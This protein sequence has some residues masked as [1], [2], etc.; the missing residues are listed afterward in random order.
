MD[1]WRK[2]ALFPY[3]LMPAAPDTC[4]DKSATPGS[5]PSYQWYTKIEVARQNCR[6]AP[7]TWQKCDEKFDW[8]FRNNLFEQNLSSQIARLNPMHREICGIDDL[9]HVANRVDLFFENRRFWTV[10]KMPGPAPSAFSILGLIQDHR[11]VCQTDDGL[12]KN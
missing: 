12:F 10:A 9:I 3:E 2:A 4:F 11:K 7:V 1:S 6:S 8:E 5:A